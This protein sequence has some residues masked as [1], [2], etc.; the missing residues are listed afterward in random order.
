MSA[1]TGEAHKSACWHSPRWLAS[2]HVGGRNENHEQ[3]AI[4]SR[5]GWWSRMQGI[6]FVDLAAQNA[7][8]HDDV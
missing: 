8:I 2:Q 7:E 1:P 5:Q 6:K 3:E 4:A